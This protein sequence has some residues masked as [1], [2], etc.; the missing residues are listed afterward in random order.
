VSWFG[1]VP[2]PVTGLPKTGGTEPDRDDPLFNAFYQ[3]VAD[4]R[5]QCKSCNTAYG[6]G[7]IVVR[8]GTVAE[9]PGPVIHSDCFK[10]QGEAA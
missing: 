5:G 3:F 7:D 8:A 2:W 4:T 6:P 1:G 10:Q 9:G